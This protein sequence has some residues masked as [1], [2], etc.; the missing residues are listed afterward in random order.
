MFCTT[1]GCNKRANS[2]TKL[3]YTCLDEFLEFVEKD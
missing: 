2:L 3:C 1:P